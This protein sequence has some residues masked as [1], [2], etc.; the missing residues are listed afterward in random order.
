MSGIAAY[1]GREMK[2]GLNRVMSSVCQRALRYDVPSLWA[3][4]T[5]WTGKGH[6]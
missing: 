3:I 6:R 1:S 2:Q 5:S 4:D